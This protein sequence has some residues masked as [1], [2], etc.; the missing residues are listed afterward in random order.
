MA[1]DDRPRVRRTAKVS[2]G[3]KRC[4]ECDEVKPQTEFYNASKGTGKRP[5]CRKC[6]DKKQYAT[7]VKTR[8]RTVRQRAYHRSMAVIKEMV[9]SET[10][11]RVVAEQLKLAEAEV[12]QVGDVVFLPGGRMVGEAAADRIAEVCSECG[13]HHRGGHECEVCGSK[14]G[15][16]A[17][18]VEIAKIVSGE[19]R[20]SAKQVTVI[21]P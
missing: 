14:P 13:D 20:F 17:R 6:D 4:T 2:A 12:A 1:G 5:Y 9:S 16:S 15:E 7:R 3:M 21:K 8:A 19:A 10:W 11:A 18:V